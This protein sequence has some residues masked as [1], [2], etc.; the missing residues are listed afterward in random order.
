M[1]QNSHWIL[2]MVAMAAADVI[3][4]D[5]DITSSLWLLICYCLSLLHPDDGVC[6]LFLRL[7]KNRVR[8]VCEQVLSTKFRVILISHIP[9]SFSENKQKWFGYRCIDRDLEM[10]LSPGQRLLLS[11]HHPTVPRTHSSAINLIC[12]WR[13]LSEFR[14]LCKS[15][16]PG[17]W[18]PAPSRRIS[19]PLGNAL[20]LHIKTAAFARSGNHPNS[21]GPVG[22]GS[23]TEVTVRQSFISSSLLSFHLAQ[24]CKPIG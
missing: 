20:N 21:P 2:T 16:S 9:D 18:I 1:L 5:M 13:K 22:R 10:C 14:E 3:T 23:H 11:P 4:V 6:D 12:R 7:F 24:R 17:L 15:Q 8:E 19:L